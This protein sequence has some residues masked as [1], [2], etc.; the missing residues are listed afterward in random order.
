[1]GFNSGLKGLKYLKIDGILP[2]YSENLRFSSQ[3]KYIVS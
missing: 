2:A 1:M 3:R